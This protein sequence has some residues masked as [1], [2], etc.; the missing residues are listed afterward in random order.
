MLTASAR[1][2]QARS[3]QHAKLQAY[4]VSCC[5]HCSVVRVESRQ[6]RTHLHMP[7]ARLH[8]AAACEADPAPRLIVIAHRP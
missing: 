4:L 6:R 3:D 2:W 1:N 8:S 7:Q 5:H